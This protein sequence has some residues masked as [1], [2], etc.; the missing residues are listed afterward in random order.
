VVQSK[1]A[2]PEAYLA[3]L[4]P[5]RAAEIAAVRDLV[6]SAL[7]AGL[8]ERMAWGMISWEVPLEAS[9]PTYN[10]QPLVHTAL[11]AQKNYNALY[12]SCVYSSPERSARLKAAFAAEG[13]KLDMGKSCLRFRRAEDLA[14][15]AIREV[16]ASVTPQEL[17]LSYEASRARSSS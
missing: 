12:L 5:A 17:I 15:D 10:C 4:D 14:Q 3:E 1:A 8:V 11:A 13:K 2:T 16:I 6:N 7:P 9:G